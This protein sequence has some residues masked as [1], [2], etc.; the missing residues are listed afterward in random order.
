MTSE[1][2]D[3]DLGSARIKR[4]ALGGVT[5]FAIFAASAGVTACAQLLIARLV[6]ADT[7]GIYAYVVA[8]MTILAYFSAL[9]FDVALLRFLPA[10]QTKGAWGL[11]RGVIQYAERR[12]LAVGILVMLAGASVIVIWSRQFTPEL[13]NTFLIGFVLVPALAL[14]WIRCS[15]VRAFGG[16]A[17][18]LVPDKIVRDGLLLALVVLT[19]LGL[20][21]HT[22][23]PLVMMATLV[24]SIVAL[25]LAS[26]AMHRLSPGMV[27]HSPPEY[28]AAT[29]RH[30]AVPLVIITAAEALLNRTGVVLLGW[31]G[32]TRE[33]GIYSL[34]FN[35]SFLVVL[36]RTA[37][38]TLFAPT[39]SS[40]FTRNDR[41]TL[42]ALVTKS[43]S[44]TLGAAACIALALA[45]LAEPVL[46]WFGKGFADGVPAL[47]IL[48]VG[49]VIA[50]SYGS[51]LYVMTMTE[52][53]RGAATLLILSAAVNVV[54]SIFLI[55]I[56]GLTGAA[57]ATTIALIVWNFAMALFISRHLRLLPG[58]LGMLGSRL[59]RSL[60]PRL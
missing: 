1:I 3:Q 60:G 41:V 38:N 50:A 18:A 25:G 49:Q 11:A 51:Q 55:S 17:L 40:L 22:T 12:V 15:I 26:V 44:W 52:H 37:I 24:G 19:S 46:T 45:V 6:G 4:V 10:Y 57:I 16:V 54:V 58:V 56:L 30:T 47:R 20:R 33:A 48:L 23:A 43:A 29:W 8:W 2:I 59:R 35:I 31:F 34:A 27:A 14:L 42:Q 36:P 9:G 39:I 5:A 13:R 53:E 7:Y 32:E 28:A 21:Q